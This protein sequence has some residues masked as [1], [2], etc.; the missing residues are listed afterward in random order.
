MH[1]YARLRALALSHTRALAHRSMY[2]MTLCMYSMTLCVEWSRLVPNDAL[3]SCLSA[4][5]SCLSF[6]HTHDFLPMSALWNGQDSCR[7]VVYSK[8]LVSSHEMVLYSKTLESSRQGL[9]RSLVLGPQKFLRSSSFGRFVKMWG[10]E[11]PPYCMH[12][13]GPMYAAYLYTYTYTSLYL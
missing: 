7:M 10:E 11:D 4:L 2:S 8:T 13:P 1:C 3:M 5:M 9:H 12:T 6:L